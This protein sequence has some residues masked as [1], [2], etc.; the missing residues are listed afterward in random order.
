M[1]PF[2]I[3]GRPEDFRVVLRLS[4]IGYGALAISKLLHISRG[5]VQ[6]WIKAK[7]RHPLYNF[8]Y[9][10]LVV[11]ERL[12]Y[13]KRVVTLK[14]I[15]YILTRYLVENYSM[16]AN[17]IAKLL[18]IQVSSVNN[19][20]NG[21]SPRSYFS[22]FID[23]AIVETKIQG[24]LPKIS[25]ALTKEWMPYILTRRL[26]EKC[27]RIKKEW[28]KD[29]KERN[30]VGP[31]RISIILSEFLNRRYAERTVSSW[32]T[33]ERSPHGF[34]KGLVDHVLVVS[35]EKDFVV[36]ITEKY[37]KYHVAMLLSS[38]G[39]RYGAISVLLKEKS[40]R[41]RGWIDKGRGPPLAKIVVDREYLKRYI[42]IKYSIKC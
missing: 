15:D 22:E 29:V 32:L 36:F 30:L 2:K 39:W 42:R 35:V 7:K 24:I 8:D 26:Y 11:E 40:D 10:S 38:R 9:D 12:R 23:D 1:K 6:S 16:S 3:D 17:R 28:K 27:K 13:A 18:G 34:N 14:N 41:I 5:R 31:R 20:S 25:S 37:V 19:W 21:N 4:K 33:G